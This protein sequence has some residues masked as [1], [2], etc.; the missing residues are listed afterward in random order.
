MS[1]RQAVFLKL[2][3]ASITILMVR[4]TLDAVSGNGQSLINTSLWRGDIVQRE[5]KQQDR[6]ELDP[7]GHGDWTSIVFHLFVVV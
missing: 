3:S 2:A 7:A 4:L 5:A 6:N 1:T